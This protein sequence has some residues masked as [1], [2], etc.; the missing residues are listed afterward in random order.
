[1]TRAVGSASVTLRRRSAKHERNVVDLVPDADLSNL[2]F[3]RLEVR[4]RLCLIY[5]DLLRQDLAYQH[6]DRFLGA[7]M[8]LLRYD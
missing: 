4:R 5:Y 2:A 1:M 6:L 3:H 8:T 7:Q